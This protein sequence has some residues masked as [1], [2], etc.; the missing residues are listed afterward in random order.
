MGNIGKYQVLG[1]IG[2][3][4]LAD[5]YLARSQDGQPSG[6]VALKRLRREWRQRPDLKELFF[7]EA[8]V[9]R[10]LQHPNIVRTHEVMH[11]ERGSL[12][13]VMEYV[14]GKN[15]SDVMA[16][17]GKDHLIAY[18]VALHIVS[19]LLAGLHYAHELKSPKGLPLDLVHRDVSPDNFFVLFNGQ[20][21][22]SDFGIAH[23]NALDGSAEEM[24]SF[25]K[26]GYMAPEQL[27]EKAIDR[28][29]DVYAAGVILYELLTGRHPFRDD[30]KANPETLVERIVN[31]RYPRADRVLPSVPAELALVLE[32]AMAETPAERFATAADMAAAFAPFYRAKAAWAP[33]LAGMM[34]QLFP[35]DFE[36]Y[37]QACK[38]V[39]T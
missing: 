10:L 9:G 12:T 8:D 37:S 17:L 23:I 11:E 31:G 35:A 38:M 21:K 16:R 28:R 3:G 34:R 36:R 19:E 4:G 13:I 39:S 5:V 29:A 1:Q 27:M 25:G 33:I 18:E 32:R 15:M 2:S 22:L 6:L 7:T 30:E 26:V 24:G 14:G 20:V